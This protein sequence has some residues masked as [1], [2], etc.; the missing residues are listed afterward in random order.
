MVWGTSIPIHAPD[1]D[2]RSP[3]DSKIKRNVT[4]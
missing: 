3:Q 4:S 2:K 1:R